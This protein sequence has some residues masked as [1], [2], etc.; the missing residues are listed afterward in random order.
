MDPVVADQVFNIGVEF[1]HLKSPTVPWDLSLW[2]PIS[3][4]KGIGPILIPC[5]RYL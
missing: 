2:R 1:S 4:S 5:R 3:S